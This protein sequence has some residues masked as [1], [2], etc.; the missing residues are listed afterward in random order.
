LAGVSAV[1]AIGL[2]GVLGQ[3]SEAQEPTERS[4]RTV[5]TFEDDGDVLGVPEGLALD[6]E[7]GMYVTLFARNEVWHLDPDSGAKEKVADVPG[8]GVRGDL[9]G[10]ERDPTDGTLLMAFKNNAGV[11][12]FDPDHPD[13]R[14]P[15]DTTTGIYRLDPSTGEVTP[16]VTRGMGVPLCFPDDIA[17]DADGDYYVT[18]LTLG[19]IWKFDRDGHGG[20]WSDHPLLGW[21]EQSGTWNSRIGAPLAYLGAN[22]VA[23]SPDGKTLFVGGDGGPGGPTGAGMIVRMP[24]NDDGSAGLPDL[25]ASGLGLNDGLEVG[26]DGTIY[27]ADMYNSDIWAFSPEGNRRLLVASASFFGDPLDNATSLV[28][29]DGCLYNTQLG[30]FKQQQGRADEALRSVV[31]ICGFGD[32]AVDGDYTPAPT[33]STEPSVPLPP[34]ARPT[35]PLFAHVNR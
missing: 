5:A 24:I 15:A 8:G 20:V 31:E 21:T 29:L 6:G 32:P 11:N 2:V 18:D 30:F 28:F 26:P 14:N 9:I 1:T 34:S 13:C 7:G 22:A 25:F 19:L 35:I 17:I 16:A 33:L 23:L 4:V 27:F 12:I 3:G 10:I